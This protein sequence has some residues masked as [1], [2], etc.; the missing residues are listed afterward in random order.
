[1]KMDCQDEVFQNM[2]KANEAH[3]NIPEFDVVLEKKTVLKKRKII[4]LNS[5]LLIAVLI[6]LSIA[7]FNKQQKNNISPKI[8]EIELLQWESPTDE[9][10]DNALNEI[11]INNM[12]TDILVPNKNLQKINNI[13]K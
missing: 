3:T 2:F 8:A 1:M 10:L 6:F 9:L 11:D 5:L 7:I 4:P 12:P 13:N